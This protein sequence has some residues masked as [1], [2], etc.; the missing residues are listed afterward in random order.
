MKKDK[1]E[2]KLESLDEESTPITLVQEDFSAY[3]RLVAEELMRRNIKRDIQAYSK[4]Q[5]LNRL[6][7]EW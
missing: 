4:E 7:P 6:M 1:Q 5:I 2:V 3:S